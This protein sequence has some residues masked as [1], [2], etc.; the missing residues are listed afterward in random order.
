MKSSQ[1]HQPSDDNLCHKLLSPTSGI[2]LKACVLSG[3]EQK[4]PL[5]S[6]NK[7]G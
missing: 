3:R 5:S 7:K 4:T 2:T 1:V 6:E